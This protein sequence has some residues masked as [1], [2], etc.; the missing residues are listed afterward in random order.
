[1]KKVF[2]I[3]VI[4]GVGLVALSSTY[5]FPGFDGTD[6]AIQSKGEMMQERGE[7]D[8][9]REELHTAIE[10][11][12]YSTFQELAPEK[13]Q[14]AISTE[15]DFIKLQ[16][17]YVAKESGDTETAKALAEELGLPERDEKKAHEWSEDREAV[18]T[19]VEAGDY[20][21][22][23]SVAGEQL[24]EKINTEDKFVTFVELHE[25]RELGDNERAQ[26]LATELG[27]ERSE[28]NGHQG[29]RGKKFLRKA[30]QFDTV[31]SYDEF[32]DAYGETRLGQKITS[33]IFDLVKELIDA[34]DAGE[35]ETMKEIA[36]EIKAS[37]QTNNQ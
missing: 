26:E 21:A 17:L 22:F 2:L 25:A 27:L 24:L 32:E 4:T 5:A 30:L 3:P 9:T 7:R 34:Y 31:D 16:A 33:D 1:M 10:A 13:F 6:G 15:A 29:K 19:A 8:A 20:E 37:L 28:G 18:R 14:E 12:D 35:R 23:M 11:G 36:Q